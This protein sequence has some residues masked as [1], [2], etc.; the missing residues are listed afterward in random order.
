MTKTRILIV[1][2]EPIV[3]KEIAF[4][5]EDHGFEIAGIAHN[6]DKALDMLVNKKPDLALLDITIIGSRN[7]I[8][9]GGIINR[10]HKIPFLYLTSHTDEETI[11]R[12]AETFPEGYLVKPF[13]DADLAP[14]IQVAL[15]KSKRRERDGLPA[16][17][18][19]NQA[20]VKGISKSEYQVIEM[21]WQGKTNTEVAEQLFISINTVKTHLTNIYRKLEVGSKPQLI[22]RL[23]SMS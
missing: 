10:K 4:N 8:E 7:G 14:A 9:L 23:R 21:V 18:Q 13:K 11:A 5:L 15:S 2:D 20:L 1:E 17:E 19:I 12:A 16:L 3:A 6:S 22:S